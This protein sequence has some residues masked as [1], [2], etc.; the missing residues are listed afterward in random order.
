M[1]KQVEFKELEIGELFECY[2]DVHLSYNR[3]KLCKCVK[4]DKITGKEIDGIVFN[5]REIDTVFRLKD[6][7]ENNDVI[8]IQNF[9]GAK[10]L[11]NEHG[12]ITKEELNDTIRDWAELQFNADF[13][14]WC[15]KKIK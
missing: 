13:T 12:L 6:E 1:R 7:L 8:T 9:P 15:D 10:L 5:I 4:L 14:E 3:R 11:V 2:G